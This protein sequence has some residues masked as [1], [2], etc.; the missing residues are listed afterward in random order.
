[1]TKNGFTSCIGGGVVVAI[2]SRGPLPLLLSLEEK[3]LFAVPPA[4]ESTANEYVPGRVTS[5]LTSNVTQVLGV[6]PATE[7]ASAPRAGRL[8]QFN[9]ACD[10]LML[11]TERNCAEILPA[12]SLNNCTRTGVFFGTDLTRNLT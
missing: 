11:A 4:G 2:T 5:V 3:R 9:V 12:R 6:V 10:Q 7:A 1:M 8:F